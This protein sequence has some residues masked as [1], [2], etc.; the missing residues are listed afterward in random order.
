MM[1]IK[2][3]LNNII[4]NREKNLYFKPDYENDNFVKIFLYEKNKKIEIDKSQDEDIALLL[5][6]TNLELSDDNMYLKISYENIYDLYYTDDHELINDYQLLGLPDLFNG[7]INV[8]NVGNFRQDKIVKYSFSFKDLTDRTNYN[9]KIYKNNILKYNQ[10]KKL[11]PKEMYELVNN[12]GQYNNDEISYSDLVKQFEC[13][14]TIKDYAEK[15]NVLLHLRLRDEEK[16]IIIDEITLDF[17]KTE[18][19]LE[20]Y[21]IVSA[22]D[23][24]FNKELLNKFDRSQK[25][26]NFYNI[27]EQGESKKVIFKNKES[28]EKIKRNRFLTGDDEL[29]FYQG[30]NE[31][32][33]DDKLDLSKYGPRV[34]GF[35]YLN[36][37]ANDWANESRDLSWFD[38]DKEPE[39][40]KLYTNTN[41]ITLKPEDKEELEAKLRKL[42]ESGNELIEVL[43]VDDMNNEFKIPLD[44]DQLVDEIKKI[45]NAIIDISDIKSVDTLKEILDIAE[46]GIQNGFIEYNG[47]YVKVYNLEYIREQLEKNRNKDNESNESQS[48][49]EALLT[50]ENL[51]EL[52]YEEE[53]EHLILDKLDIPSKLKGELFPHQKEG[54]KRLQSLYLANKMNGMLLADDMG[55]GKT[56]Q[57]LTFL[58]WIKERN[59]LNSVLIVAP[60]TLINNWDNANPLDKGEIQKFFPYDLFDTYKLKGRINSNELEN[61]KNHDI[62]FTSY[63]SLRINHVLLGQIKWDVMICDEAQKVKNSTTQVSV[64]VKS[65][66]A[67]FKIACS[68]TPIENSLLDL[69]NIADYA[70]PGILGARDDFKKT[71]VNNLADEDIS[72]EQRKQINDDL[73]ER[74]EEN[75]LRRNKKDHI[76]DLPNKLI[77]IYGFQANENEKEKINR[78]NELKKMGHNHLPLIQKKISLCS[79]PA[80]ISKSLFEKS[81]V[82]NYLKSST[83]L[84]HLRKLINPIKEKEEKVLIFTIFKKMQKII[85]KTISKWYGFMP[86][87]VNGETAQNKR[88]KIFNEFRNSKGF[89]IIV[90]SP[91]VAG[92][93]INLV[94]AN[95]VIHYTRMWNPAKEDQ[96]TDRIYRIGQHKDVHVYY[97]ILSLDE[98]YESHFKNEKEYVN[99]FLEA[100]IRKA[101]PEEKL[102]KLLVDKKNL[103]MNFFFAAGETKIDLSQFDNDEDSNNDYLTINN[104]FDFLNPLEFEILISKLYEQKGYKTFPTVQSGDNGVDV[105]CL[106]DNKITLIQCKMTNEKSNMPRTAINELIG[107]KNIY[108]NNLDKEIDKLIVISTSEKMTKQTAASAKH[109]NVSVILYKDLANELINNRIYYSEIDVNKNNRYS[110]EKLRKMI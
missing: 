64:A 87:V 90:L 15:T 55:L 66:N 17:K 32:W 11:L 108:A 93:G 92:V 46:N 96:A 10:T 34:K 24:E 110:L 70:V 101:S 45:T 8:D 3:L 37:R 61:L 59:E 65:Q 84:R 35:G 23:E 62:V 82:N 53:S 60:T 7:Y 52:E 83:K 39:L 80:L 1:K 48:K 22:K 4:N 9:I 21:P 49:T 67:K 12:I 74:V 105:V 99:Q 76:E 56:L 86:K 102:N 97:P 18:D 27:K 58:A 81:D 85:V 94:E 30:K 106:N 71:Y 31:I 68:A 72:N 89:N 26:R 95:H 6:L 19:G 98:D 2:D 20:I 103:L 63:T 69:W 33:E 79:H 75:F 16:P 38:L 57:L 36:Y 42:K 41:S 5:S 14:K 51:E 47:K 107:A 104:I 77:H 88:T 28:A 100:D 43:L 91:E 54:L 44:E 78:L 50:Y 13:F 109:N 29:K 25:V 40:P 73:V